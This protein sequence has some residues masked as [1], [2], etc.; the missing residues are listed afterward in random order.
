MVAGQRDVQR[1]ALG[2][3]G[4]VQQRQVVCLPRRDL[5]GDKVGQPGVVLR[6]D[7][8]D[9]VG[10]Q[11]AVERGDPGGAAL[12]GRV[13]GVREPLL[14]GALLDEVARAVDNKL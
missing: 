7:G 10:T 13:G 12:P 5:D 9:Q 14:L 2:G 11:R 3:G 1:V 6:G 8:S 4:R